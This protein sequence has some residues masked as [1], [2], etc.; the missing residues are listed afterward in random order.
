VTGE[1]PSSAFSPCQNSPKFITTHVSPSHPDNNE[2]FAC[3]FN[4]AIITQNHYQ[5]FKN[6]TFFNGKSVLTQKVI[7]DN[8]IQS[9]PRSSFGEMSASKHHQ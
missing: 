8:I 1:M 7:N 3:E 6:A 2:G 5:E 9:C 4:T